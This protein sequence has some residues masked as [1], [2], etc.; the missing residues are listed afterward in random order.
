M[1]R[2]TSYAA[3]RCGRKR[4]RPRGGRGFSFVELLV[5]LTIL[6]VGVTAAVRAL[7]SMGNLLAL[8]AVSTRVALIAG[9]A[10]ER[11]AGCG[12]VVASGDTVTGAMRIQWVTSPVSGGTSVRVNAWY[13]RRG[14][15]HN[16]SL[17]LTRW[18][19]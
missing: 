8:G 4:H 18:C 11:A 5:A 16:W 17:E 3:Y 10:A 12:T 13:P 14:T 15:V 7:A 9:T 19:G 2:R 1:N 6:A